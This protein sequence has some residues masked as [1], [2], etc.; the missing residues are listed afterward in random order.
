M[1]K[2]GGDFVVEDVPVERVEGGKEPIVIG[3]EILRKGWIARD[4]RERVPKAVKFVI[5]T[6]SNV[7][8]LY[9]QTFISTFEQVLHIKPFVKVLPPGEETKSR[10]VKEE[11][12]DF[13]LAKACNR[14]TCV[15][16]LG[17]GVIGDL[18]GF[19]AATY[20]RGVPFVQVPTTLLAMVDSSIGGK[21]GLNPPAGKNLV[22]AFH[23]PKAVYI[24]LSLL[25]TLPQREF[26]NGL[27]EVIKSGVIR[28]PELFE[29]LETNVDGI[30]NNRE[31]RLLREIVHRSAK[32]KAEVVMMDANENGIRCILNYGHTIGHAIEAFAFPLLLHGECVSIGMVL[33]SKL[34]QKMNHL[35]N[36]N[37]IGRLTRCLQAYKLPVVVPKPKKQ[38]GG[39]QGK[40]K[41]GTLEFTP[42]DL[43]N[44]MLI[45]KKNANSN[46]R[47]V[48][49]KD[50]GDVFEHPV[51]VDKDTLRF[52]L[53]PSVAVEPTQSGVS[54]VITVPGSKSISNRVLTLAAL[55]EGECHIKGLLSADDTDVMLAA[56]RRLGVQYKWL[57]QGLTLYIKGSGGQLQPPKE[58]E[59]PFFLGN[60]GTASR[61][62][63]TMCTLVTPPAGSTEKVSTILTGV[64][65]LKE[66]PI[67]D[68]VEALRENGCVINYLEKEGYFPIEVVGGK[69]LNG[70][71][72]NLSA[73]LSSQYVSSILLSAPYALNDVDLQIKGEAVSQPFIEMTIKVMQQFGVKVVDTSKEDKISWFIPRG[74][75]HN[76]KDF[77]VEPDASSAS[78]P[79]A[80][81]AI[82]GGEIT[83]DNIGSS[84]VQGDAQFYTVMEKMGCTV[85][86]T[87]TSTTVKGPA[88]GGLKAVDIDM[89]SMTDTF[90]TVAVLAAVA[91]GT[92]RIYNIA[93][94]RVKECN[95]IAAMVKELGKCGVTA[96]ELE[97]GLEIDGCG[98]DISKLHGASIECY[99][100]HRIAM[101]FGVFGTVVPGILITDKECVDK[102]Y[103][104]FWYDLEFR[105]GVRLSVPSTENEQQ[106]P[107]TAAAEAPVAEQPGPDGDDRSV[108]L[109]GMRGSGKSTMG[110]ALAAG[111]G[112]KFIDID[113]EFEAFAGE[114]IRS[115]VDAHGWPAFRAKEEELVRQVV[116][117]HPQ[118][119]VI[120]TGGGIVETPTA[121]EYLLA[122]K[123]DVIIVQLRRNV[124]DVIE[125]LSADVSRADLGEE[126]R[127]IWER[128]RPLYEQVSDHEFYIGRGERDWAAAERDLVD[129]V[130]RVRRGDR[131]PLPLPGLDRDTGESYFLSLTTPRVEECLPFADELFA[132]VD[133]IEMRVDLMESQDEDF[134]REQTA[135]LRR[136]TAKPLLFTLRT[137]DQG[138][139]YDET[140]RADEIVRLFGLAL[141]LGV[142]FID[143]E[144]TL[145]SEIVSAVLDKRRALG[146]ATR[147]IASYHQFN[148]P[149]KSEEDV[150]RVLQRC[151]ALGQ[152][153]ALSASSLVDVVKVVIFAF[154]DGDVWTL[155]NGVKR[156]QE[157]VAHLQGFP[158]IALAA[159]E[160]GKL[161]RVMNKFLTPVTHPLLPAKAAP[162]QLSVKEIKSVRGL[163]DM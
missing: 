2:K 23:H 110:S 128:R 116:G 149:V 99:R 39:D 8:G 118:R 100:D 5:I 56:L 147:V 153:G 55:G 25:K 130:Q 79:L 22:G 96:R 124:E 49:V 33:E 136:R 77:V 74:V 34:A 67:S 141:R 97:D 148:D 12:E 158:T 32:M 94:Q 129:L 106:K 51:V 71:V 65:R 30:L 24:D 72:I 81:A 144:I 58:P 75:Y 13:M 90:M 119:T 11:I 38:Q 1:Q 47:C 87:T 64:D 7:F 131:A 16:A 35:K 48:I 159:G 53:L 132:D 26:C 36:L 44:K 108:V 125:Y 93:N 54:G 143:L 40:R 117:A 78:Y 28:D 66:R 114:K 150:V 76:P 142:E 57:D 14:D 107:A 111:L 133:L 4:I 15:V 82:T 101:S 68:L 20:L 139:R 163:L 43:I 160:K 91:T 6:D 80:L 83:V 115:F 138:G 145:Q 84:S 9:G 140:G 69:G 157:T 105:F 120:S 137:R 62:L 18:A 10:Q 102:T 161:S 21:T 31:E 3:N 41:E 86:Q 42:E 154:A 98:G 156:A 112:W 127:K 152:T 17:G 59:I 50:F 104:D 123:K 61:F 29:L 95:R 85:N 27:A 126:T 134:L 135:L 121:F 19:V 122:K 46:I 45:D 89:S 109:V 162:G 113:V 88:R 103:P 37:F 52:V 63:T 92:S 146:G 155:R 60:A 151:H 73:K 70:G